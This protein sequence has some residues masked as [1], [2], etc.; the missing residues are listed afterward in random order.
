MM[1]TVPFLALFLQCLRPVAQVPPGFLLASLVEMTGL[2]NML[3]RGV[4]WGLILSFL[5]G[6][7]HGIRGKG[8]GR[9]PYHPCLGELR[10]ASRAIAPLHALSSVPGGIT[11]WD[12]SGAGIAA[13]SSVPG[14]E[15]LRVI[16]YFFR[17]S[18]MA[19]G[20]RRAR[21]ASAWTA[22]L[23]SANGGLVWTARF[24]AGHAV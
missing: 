24:P 11:R 20:G 22:S 2:W 15:A 5:P 18:S 23:S 6:G 4:P 17:S 13:L 8:P 3:C 14:G 16:R 1:G 9:L 7:R 10:P 12:G 21:S 19:K